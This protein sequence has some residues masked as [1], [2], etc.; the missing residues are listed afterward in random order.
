[1]STLAYL[2]IPIESNTFK[3]LIFKINSLLKSINTEEF[4]ECNLRSIGF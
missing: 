2:N 1:M 3:N 4:M